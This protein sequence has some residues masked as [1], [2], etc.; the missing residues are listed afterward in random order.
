MFIISA[1]W[2]S[3][4]TM[5]AEP[6]KMFSDIGNVKSNWDCTNSI[7]GPVWLVWLFTL[8]GR[9]LASQLSTPSDLLPGNIKTSYNL[10]TSQTGASCWRIKILLMV[11]NIYIL[12]TQDGVQYIFFFLTEI[13]CLQ[14][15]FISPSP[16]IIP[17]RYSHS[18]PSF[19]L[20]SL[21]GD[22]EQ[23]YDDQIGERDLLD[24][25]HDDN[26]SLLFHDEFK[27]I[28]KTKVCSMTGCFRMV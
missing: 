21:P 26:R 13:Y 6:N 9:I 4:P 15:L 8:V 23:Q 28:L 17:R 1:Q 11:S 5:R 16:A 7:A 19:K 25:F 18:A 20:P 22:E 3:P 14:S 27:G 2:L 24:S 10:Q 12:L